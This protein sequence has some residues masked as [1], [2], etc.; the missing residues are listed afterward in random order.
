MVWLTTRALGSSGPRGGGVGYDSGEASAERFQ[1]GNRRTAQPW[2]ATNRPRQ[3]GRE[4]VTPALTTVGS[5]RAANDILGSDSASAHV[6]AL[7]GLALRKTLRRVR[8]VPSNARPPGAGTILTPTNGLGGYTW[9][10][11]PY[12]LLSHR[13]IGAIGRCG[14]MRAGAGGTGEADGGEERESAGGGGYGRGGGQRPAGRAGRG[15]GAGWRGGAAERGAARAGGGG[16]NG[17]RNGG[18]SGSGKAGEGCG[19]VAPGGWRWSG[20]GDT[21]GGRRR[22]G[23][24]GFSS[25]TQGG[26]AALTSNAKG[27]ATGFTPTWANC[28]G[29]LRW[30][31]SF[32]VNNETVTAGCIQTRTHERCRWTLV[33]RQ[34]SWRRA[35]VRRAAGDTPGER[36]GSVDLEREKGQIGPRSTVRVDE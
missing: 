30:R 14:Y 25:S 33:F 18:G 16:R 22:W 3:N 9:E 17:S 10:K 35:L 34:F 6:P 13:A 29:W 2:R 11:G 28:G 31:P 24:V 21:K 20:G 36:S 19:E 23:P 4:P 27:T 5:E 32:I 15:G 1:R 8:P 7:A 26:R 12:R